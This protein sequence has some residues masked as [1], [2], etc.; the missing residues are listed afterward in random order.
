MRLAPP[1]KNGNGLTILYGNNEKLPSG[2][3]WMVRN[4]HELAKSRNTN[5]I[6]RKI[7]EDI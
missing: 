5:G 6:Q 7:G 3:L 2:S 4:K 1:P